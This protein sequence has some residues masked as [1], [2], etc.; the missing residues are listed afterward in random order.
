MPAKFGKPWLAFVLVFLL[1]ACAELRYSQSSPGAKD[2]HPKK[3][4]VLPADVAAY[5]EARGV[6]EEI[7]GT[8]LTD[9]GWFTEVI[10]GSALAKRMAENA[11]LRTAVT[12]YTAKL[13]SLSF[14]DPEASRRIA[15]LSGADALLAVNVDMWNYAREKDDKFAKVGLGMRLIDAGSAAIVWKAGDLAIDQYRVIKPE[16]ADVARSLV[17]R[18]IDYMPH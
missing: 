12:A 7:V 16:L 1:A 4:L 15:D 8:V 5:G 13:N 17:K 14:S 9:R 3:V 11:E 2:F 6:V 18:I 10:A